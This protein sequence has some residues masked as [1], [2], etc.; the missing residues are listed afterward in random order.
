MGDGPVV[1]V[2]VGGNGDD[3]V[4][5]A[6]GSTVGEGTIGV[7]LAVIAVGVTGNGREVGVA[8]AVALGTAVAVGE[9][10]GVGWTSALTTVGAGSEDDGIWVAAGVGSSVGSGEGVGAASVGSGDGVAVASVAS[11]DGVAAGSVASGD[12][13]T[14]SG[15]EYSPGVPVMSMGVAVGAGAPEQAPSSNKA[16]TAAGAPR[17]AT[18]RRVRF[19]GAW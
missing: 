14:A 15:V 6:C 4:A 3:G 5:V 19:H 17:R 16:A 18:S 12:G 9:L 1:G 10:G 7:G 11:G 13:V 2:A 8:T